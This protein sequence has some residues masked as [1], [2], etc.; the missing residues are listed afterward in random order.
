[1]RS[2][3]V[4]IKRERQWERCIYIYIYIWKEEGRRVLLLSCRKPRGRERWEN[5]PD[6]ETPP[7]EMKNCWNPRVTEREELSSSCVDATR[8]REE[9]AKRESSLLLHHKTERGKRLQRV[10]ERE[11]ERMKKKVM[12]KW[13]EG[14]HLYLYIIE[15]PRLVWVTI[16]HVG[17]SLL[18][19]DQPKCAEKQ[20][21]AA[22]CSAAK[23]K[24]C[25]VCDSLDLRL[26][27]EKKFGVLLVVV[28]GFIFLHCSCVNW[29]F[30]AS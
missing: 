3:E 24:S 7:K 2:R 4:K 18:C 12:R 9:R 20:R 13:R 27:R 17:W 14:L 8:L 16:D 30:G 21:A 15:R 1:V 23:E 6:E 5:L 29:Y 25:T 26:A 10:T 22:L 28:A 11:N 19:G